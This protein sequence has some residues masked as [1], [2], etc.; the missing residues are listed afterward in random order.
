VSGNPEWLGELKRWVQ[1]ERSSHSD[2]EQR[3]IFEQYT[4]VLCRLS[5]NHPL[6][7][8]LDDLQW[9]DKGSVGLLFHLGRRVQ[10]ERVLIVGAYW[11]EE[12]ALQRDGVP[13]PTRK[14]MV[15]LQRQFGDVTLDLADIDRAEGYRF[16]EAVLDTEPN[17]L[18]QEFRETLYRRTGSHP[19]FTVELLRTMQE[20]GD[21]VRDKGTDGAWVEGA[22]LDWGAL[23]ARVE[24]VIKLV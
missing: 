11:P 5:N 12:V 2:L 24:A 1:R 19:L 8:V 14:V 4:N 3:A 16:V 17:R 9:A 6:L 18:D 7:L 15:E 21:I 10:S 22:A 23:P 13:H 20:R